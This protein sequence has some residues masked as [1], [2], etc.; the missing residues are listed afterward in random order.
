ML[1]LSLSKKLLFNI[2][3]SSSYFI[4]FT[5]SFIFS[6]TANSIDQATREADRLNT[7]DKIEE[8]LRRFPKKPT[9]RIVEKE[10]PPDEGKKVLIKKIN[11]IGCKEVPAET[12]APIISQYENKELSISDINNLAKTIEREYLKQGVIAVVYIPAQETKDRIINFTVVEAKMGKLN[13]QEHKYY[14]KFV[15]MRYWDIY[16]GQT[17]RY[18]K[19]SKDLQVI[20]KN[21]DREVKTALQAGEKSGTTDVIL[22]A[23]TNF[24]AH[25]TATFDN[26]GAPITGRARKGYGMRHNNFLGLD[27]ILLS[28]YSYGKEFS[29]RYV[30]HSLPIDYKGTSILYGWSYSKSSP[31]NEYAP[32]V[33]I[34]KV[35][36]YV[37]SVHR[38]LFKKDTYLGEISA[39]FEANDKSITQNTGVYNRDRL[40]M[41]S[42][43]GTFIQRGLNNTTVF[44]PGLTQG[45]P[46]FGASSRGNPLASRNA[47]SVFT[48]FNF[49]VQH[50][51]IL[52]NNFQANLK[53]KTQFAGQ[54]LMP[55]EELGIG[56]IDSVRGYPSADYLADNALVLNTELLMPSI[57]IP[58]NLRIPFAKDNLR[59]QVTTLAFFD[60]GWG[61]RK[62]ALPTE[63]SDVNMASLGAGIRVKLFDQAL[64]RLE[65][66]FPVAMHAQSAG[67]NSRFHFAVDFQ[68]K[69]PEEIERI[70]KVAEEETIRVWAIRLIDNE[71]NQPDSAVR[72]KIT[73]YLYAARDAYTRQETEEAN[74]YYTKVE[75]L[76]QALYTQAED[77]ARNALEKKKKLTE[78][79][80]TA[81][82]NFKQ[83]KFQ[84][85][86][87][88]WMEIIQKAEPDP[89]SLEF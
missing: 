18:D 88:I 19:I 11:L 30:Y 63:A 43:N 3:L 44:S 54:K 60:Y 85:A 75:A 1:K 80:K 35:Q 2:F 62:G 87:K 9:E 5:P 48:R 37:F 38:D 83:G 78:E 49:D 13:V 36:S 47:K 81:F 20:N 4:F 31:K 39:G 72:R 27:D 24:P 50:R 40:R 82:I 55:Q 52:P 68:D 69:L 28:G 26:E 41:L 79:N 46:I 8:Q 17:L 58:Q 23:K 65:W 53:L 86:E 15:L 89:F 25:L 71:M 33:L 32:S 61:S 57:F 42:F 70:R 56:G 10:T 64:M 59:D 6:Q 76:C 73:Q 67:G 16:P 45:L 74:K 34:S 21:P 84:E 12:F 66:G 14:N 22:T 7:P 51:R 29:G 77:Y